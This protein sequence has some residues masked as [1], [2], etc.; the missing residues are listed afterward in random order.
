KTLVNLH[1]GKDY[2]IYFFGFLPGFF[3]LGGLDKRLFCA[4]KTSPRKLVPKGSVGIGGEQT[5][6]YPHD[7]P[8]G[9]QIIGRTPV[10]LFNVKTVPPVFAEIGDLIR[11]IPVDLKE[12]KR[13]EY[14]KNDC[15]IKKEV[16]T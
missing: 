3:Y 2:P 11:F 6:I 16:L 14:Q 1:S 8:G 10:N 15:Q 13:I 9:W 5:G 12:F 4:R 7:S